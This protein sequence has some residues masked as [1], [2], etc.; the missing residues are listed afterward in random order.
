MCIDHVPIQER[1]A[2]LINKAGTSREADVADLVRIDMQL[3]ALGSNKEKT[4][5]LICLSIHPWQKMKKK[6]IDEENLK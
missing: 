2:E 4:K 6:N 3:K 5:T 1:W